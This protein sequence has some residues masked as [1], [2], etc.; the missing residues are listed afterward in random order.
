MKSQSDRSSSAYQTR[1]KIKDWIAKYVIKLGGMSTIIAISLIFF[2]LLYE[3]WPLFKS[4]E[5]NQ[6]PDTTQSIKSE[7][8]LHVTLED[9]L[10]LASH[11]SNLGNITYFKPNAT[12]IA[13]SSIKYKL[14][15][16][17]SS[18]ISALFKTEPG[19]DESDND[20]KKTNSEA[21]IAGLDTGSVILFES[22]Y[23]S[24]FDKQT[25]RHIKPGITYPWGKKPIS[26]GSTSPIKLITGEFDE[27]GY[28]IVSLHRSGE[29]RITRIEKASS[30]LDED[31]ESESSTQSPPKL[32]VS[33]SLLKPEFKDPITH[34]VLSKDMRSLYIAN[35]NGGLSYYNI[36]SVTSPE[37]IQY[38]PTVNNGQ[39]ITTLKLLI[40]GISILIGNSD[41]SIS[42]W[43]PIKNK[44]KRSAN[45]KTTEKTVIRLK[46][47]REFRELKAP[48]K[49][50]AVEYTRKGF[51]A[52]D[53]A[54]TLGIFHSTAHRTLS[55]I[56]TGIKSPK[57][58]YLSPRADTVLVNDGQK[59]HSFSIDNEHPEI[60]WSVLW[61]KVWYESR[62]KPLFLWQSSASSDDAE[63]KLSLVPLTTGTLK[64][65]FYAMLISVPL[66]I[67]GAIFTANFMAPSMRKIVKPGIEI[68]EALPTVVIGFL[69]ALWL[70]PIIDTNLAGVF[71]I[72]ITLPVGIVLFGYFW[73][74]APSQIRNSFSDGWEAAILLPVI[75]IVAWF[76]LSVLG[77]L[78]D[79]LF[80]NGSMSHWLSHELGIPY[81][82]HNSMIVGLAMG[83]AV[84]PTIFSIAE[85][86]IFAVPKHLI[87]G[88]LALG[89]TAW[90]TLTR[91]VILTASPGIFSAIMIGFGRAIGETM[92]VLM[93]TGNT[94]V[95]D[96]NL[97]TGM[98]TLSAN[99]AT[100][101]PEA[102]RHS[103]HFRVLFLTAL[104][105]F[106]FTFVFNS[107]AE[108]VRHRL[109]NKYSSL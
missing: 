98:R 29:L 60:S 87:Q 26:L 8:T 72:L 94:P 23:T 19:K 77:P 100:E 82:R 31:E 41:G 69:A 1:R 62:D 50:I 102:A 16:P 40:G 90:Q 34:L 91:V 80:F 13:S 5:I 14:A 56:N 25:K 7:R 79:T 93:A 36:A 97:F 20:S 74:R 4:T 92:I 104:V 46:K 71:L 96:M 35:K 68:M 33:H 27:D 65:A 59:L 95:T 81:K 106:I 99:I 61:N 89:A 78:C 66:A 86:A 109:R 105:L 6:H 53:N 24:S 55:I 52:I 108:I 3:V 30:S 37:L 42:Q 44:I 83:F 11:I 49:D 10:L 9:K 64:A 54:G 67:F 48:V 51:V 88:S 47:I 28:T 107:I 18:A 17:A 15:L 76:T 58:L 63:P 75:L 73:E 103:T 85:D 12:S 43:F 57:A 2:Y 32:S 45:G 22:H 70:A 21:F 101:L 39:Q 38:L 84:I